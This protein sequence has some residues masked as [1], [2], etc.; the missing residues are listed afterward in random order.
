MIV[1]YIYFVLLS[2]GFTIIIFICLRELIAVCVARLP[3]NQRWR[4]N[5]GI[6]LT[7]VGMGLYNLAVLILGREVFGK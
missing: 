6:T 5:F 2:G 1:K 7:W 3:C 4:E